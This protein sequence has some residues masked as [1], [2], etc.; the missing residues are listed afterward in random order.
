VE[1]Q[2]EGWARRILANQQ[3]VAAS[4]I[5]RVVLKAFDIS[6]E[7]LIEK[8]RE[9]PVQTA[10]LLTYRLFRRLTDHSYNQIGRVLGCDRSTVLDGVASINARI[11]DNEKF[12]IVAVELERQI[13]KEA[14]GDTDQPVPHAH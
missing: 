3:Y 14:R 12:A 8:N 1:D 10:R 7:E 2:V 5:V 4:I 13:L 6:L 11:R 9:E